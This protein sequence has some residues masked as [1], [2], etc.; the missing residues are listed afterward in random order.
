MYLINALITLDLELIHTWI[1]IVLALPLPVRES[2][3]TFAERAFGVECRS[4]LGLEC[5]ISN[6]RGYRSDHL[7]GIF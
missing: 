1:V 3:D 4:N 7:R 2:V 6:H 5:I